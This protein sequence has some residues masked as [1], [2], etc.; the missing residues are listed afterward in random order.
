[1][2]ALRKITQTSAK[3]ARGMAAGR[4]VFN[5]KDPLGLESQLSDEELMIKKAA[6]D[7]CQGKLLPRIVEA[8]R[9][10]TFD[11]E[12]MKEMGEMGFLGPT[13]KGYGCPGV[14]YVSY[15]LIANAVERVDSAYRSAMSVQSSL[16]MHPINTFGSEEQKE[17]YLPRLATG[18]LIGCFGLTE[19]NH[20]SDPGSMETRAKLQGGKYILNGSKNWITNAPIADLF[21]IWAKDDEGDIRGFLLEKDFPGLTTQYI[22]GKATLMA[23][24]TGMVIDRE[25]SQIFME[26]VE[27]PK[28]N[29]LPK[30]KGLKGPFTCLNSARYGISW[31]ALGAAYSC[32]DIARQ[33]TLDRKQ[34][35]APL[36]SNQLIQKKLA[37]M[38]T[39]ISIGLQGCLQV[40]R[41]LD[42][43]K[44]P[45]ENISMVKRNSCGK[46][47]EIARAARDMLGGNGLSDEYHIIRHAVNLEAVNTYEG[48][49]DIHALILGRAITGLPS[50]G[51]HLAA[52]R[53]K[54]LSV[55][56]AHSLGVAASFPS[57]RSRPRRVQ[58]SQK[59]RD[60]IRSVRAC[61][62]AAEER[63]VIAKESAL[64]RTAF[65]D[66]DKQY[67]HRNVAKLLFI[68]MLGYPSH[69][70][71]MECV[72]LIASPYFAEKRM[73]Y[74]GLILLLTDQEEVLTLV[75]NSMQLDLNHSNPFIVGLS[76]TAVG[77]IASPDMARDLVMDIDRQLRSES[78][79]LR[80]K[81]ALAAIRVFR[82]VPELVE[83]FIDSIHALLKSKNH[84]VLLAGVQLI[85]EVILINEE[86]LRFFKDLV[87][88]LVRH[89]RNLLSMGYSSE[90]DVS[91]IADPFLQVEILKLLRILGRNNE[92]ASEAM[93]DVL[94]QVATNTE[95]AKTAGNAILYECVQTIMTIES[96]NGLKVL[97]INIL[98]RFLLNRD[99]NIRY[100]AL[101]TLSKVIVDDAAAVQRHTN[102]IV[103]CLKDP[104]AS[105]R[106][107][108][109]ELIYALVNET[110]IQPLAREMLNYLVVAP[111][112]LKPTLCSKI[113]DAV[114]RYAPSN[115]WHIDTIIT[116]LSIAGSTN[117]DERISNSLIMLIQRNPDLHA[118][119]AHKLCWALHD[120]ASQQSLVHVGIWCIGEYGHLLL[121]EAPAS[122][123]TISDKGRVEESAVV[124]LFR[125]IL[126]HH[127]ATDVTRAYALNAAVKL[128]TRFQQP[129]EINKL[130]KLIGS[131]S[132]SMVLEL[133][134]RASEYTTL[135]QPRWSSL[136]PDVL[137]NIPAVDM[138]KV[139]SR[140]ARMSA[141]VADLMS[142]DM[143]SPAAD[144]PV[145]A[146][147]APKKAP[148][149]NLLDLDD[150]FGGGGDSSA[151]ASAPAAPAPAAPATVD[152]LADIFSVGSTAPPPAPTTAPTMALD[153]LADLLGG[154][155][156]Q[157]QQQ[158]Q[159]RTSSGSELL[160]LMDF[161]APAPAPAPAVPQFPTVRAYEKGPLSVDLDITKPKKDDLSVTYINATFRN[162][163]S[164]NVENFV[165]L[166]AFP[167]YIKL[168][169]EAPSGTIVPANNAGV[170]TQM[171]KIQ[172]TMQGE[173]P[174]LMR[175]K[176]EFV[177]NGTKIDEM[178]TVSNFPS[179]V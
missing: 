104:D 21:L 92:D 35:G 162:S 1:M 138:S 18:E 76:L 11:K 167:K 127:V 31:G 53:V 164:L 168:K 65:K 174:V 156:A 166:A 105:I 82:K 109:L 106:Q 99:N 46:S 96:D 4:A 97:A 155:V 94:A 108:A 145:K 169:M 103:D 130:N 175:I 41:M 113:A 123:D 42:E 15:G 160:G 79:H 114:E 107:R 83:D 24:A 17:K 86:N 28:E 157:P 135:G 85:T 121:R 23:S 78:D 25:L 165:F 26:D 32:Y 30:V 154:P 98:G 48:T 131:F 150:I 140:S 27:V 75:T 54:A 22:H 177:V 50:F 139:R 88:N 10:A 125:R 119:V 33:Y 73:G 63:A 126:R 44:A 171:V 74:L 66:Q 71:Q 38:I 163:S 111:S 137:A 122:E 20:G 117:L 133:Q 144:A 72:K 120:D 59:L 173:K 81:A 170:V 60:L 153:P 132:S 101:N 134:Q 5:W 34:F 8:N 36:A 172:N 147:E 19:P 158:S 80:K 87:P 90:Y 129:D 149:Q 57:L 70:G 141:A 58:M 12:I 16:V 84:G 178:A 43:G 6:N 39:E 9:N 176:L 95:T 3:G 151:P 100:V 102:T 37:D 14:N 142:E 146:F 112:E 7:Y 128:T 91:G 93:N 56:R 69:F 55:P 124:D 29:M 115:R 64:I 77:N 110:N 47:L 116:M 52:L 152:L 118:Y 51:A 68:H 89:L 136:R 40:G 161:G 49:H 148:Q 2:L 143:G 159:Q 62:T 67:R 45:V 179:N 13:I 61:K